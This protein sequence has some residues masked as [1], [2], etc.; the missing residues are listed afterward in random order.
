MHADLRK[1][2]TVKALAVA[3][4]LAVLGACSSMPPAMNPNTQ[5]V[6]LSGSNEVPAV[7]SGAAGSGWV[8]VN[9]D[10]TV[11]AKIT[12]TGMNATMAHIHMA[13]AGTN[14]PVI[15]PF[16]KTADNVFEAPAGAKMTDAQ[17]A[18]YKSGNTYVNVHSAAHPGGEVRAQLKP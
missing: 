3:G 9:S 1:R 6:A 4:A 12:V 15:V 10:M 16:V 7:T 11:A 14:G 8:T 17:Y 5:S 18:A 13:A 2:F